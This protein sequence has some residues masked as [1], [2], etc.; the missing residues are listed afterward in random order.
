MHEQ[1]CGHRSLGLAVALFRP[2]D[3]VGLQDP[4]QVLLPARR[5]NTIIRKDPI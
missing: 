1:H 5:K 2:V 4:E 3:G